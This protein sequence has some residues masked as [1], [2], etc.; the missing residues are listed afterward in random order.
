MHAANKYGD[1][2]FPPL[3]YNYQSSP[4][5]STVQSV[6][7]IGNDIIIG[8][9]AKK[10]HSRDMTIPPGRWI[11]YHTKE[12]HNSG[13]SS[14][15]ISN[16]PAYQGSFHEFKVP[17]YIR[18]GAVIP[19]IL[20]DDNTSE[21]TGKKRRNS[22]SDITQLIVEAYVDPDVSSYTFN[23]YEDDDETNDYKTTGLRTTE[24]VNTYVSSSS[25]TVNI[26]GSTGWS[27]SGDRDYETRLVVENRKVNGVTCKIGT[28]SPI[29]LTVRNN[30]G[31]Y[32]SNS[33]GFY[34]DSSSSITF[35]KVAG[36][37]IQDDKLFT[38]T[39]Q[40]ITSTSSIQFVA[41]RSWTTYGDEITIVGAESILGSWN[42][43]NSPRAHWRFN[44]NE[45]TWTLVVHGITSGLTN[46]PWKPVE[47]PGG[48]CNSPIWPSGS[49]S[50]FNTNSNG[51]YSG[52]VSRTMW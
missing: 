3:I 19:K 33:E 18:G 50:I 51:G 9:F 40:S 8:I 30:R 45:Q 14:S 15:T 31:A 25:Q 43:C 16:V 24:L 17:V 38:F 23:L 47:L 5:L 29:T 28:D 11:N 42:P 7:M 49:N 36:K 21:I 26:K 41:D 44:T 6:K 35:A 10:D 27:I 12:Y 32:D 46:S 22:A 37:G 20:V 52:S 34:Y 13:T 48:N 4:E 1:A 2:V 39:T